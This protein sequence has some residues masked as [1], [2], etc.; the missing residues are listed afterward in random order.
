LKIENGKLGDAGVVDEVSDFLIK[1]ANFAPMMKRI[2]LLAVFVAAAAGAQQPVR[3]TLDDCLDYAMAGSLVREQMVLSQQAAQLDLR[4][5]QMERLPSLSASASENLGH[6]RGERRTVG[7]SYGVSAGMPLFQGGAINEG[8]KQSKLAAAEAE[9]RTAQWDNTLA[10]NILG[11][12]FTLLG[13]EE[14]QRNQQSLIA[15][16]ERQVRDAEIQLKVGEILESDLLMLQAQLAQNRNS[17]ARTEIDLRNE[18]LNLKGLMSMPLE[19]ELTL[20]AADTLAMAL[21][22]ETDFVARAEQVLPDLE[23]LNYGV[24]AAK[25]TLKIARAAYYPSLSLSGGLGTGHS[26]DFNRWRSQVESRFNQSAGVSMSVPIFT[27]GRT[28]TSVGRSKIA[29]RQAELERQQGEMDVRRS[30][31]QSYSDALAAQNDYQTQTVRENA[32]RRALDVARAQYNAHTIKP[33][34]MLQQENNYIN[35]MYQFVQSKYGFMLRRKIL[36]VYT[37]EL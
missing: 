27:R 3:F 6:Q 14:L 21:P 22:E 12:Y 17:V 32:Y 31:I 29:L 7:G 25:S 19:T 23:L 11:S 36:D 1:I 35:V 10:I 4:Q 30:L 13:Y 5:S 34:D 18:M 33:V 28:R 9:V 20:A 26:D 16:G 8:I 15:V 2:L 37:R 24:E